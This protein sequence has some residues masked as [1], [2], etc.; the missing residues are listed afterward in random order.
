MSLKNRE[1]N[2]ERTMIVKEDFGIV[3]VTARQFSDHMTRVETT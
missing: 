2:W 1:S 3:T